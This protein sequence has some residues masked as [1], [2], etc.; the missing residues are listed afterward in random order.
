M[1]VKTKIQ[2][3][4]ST[5]NPT[6]GC[7]GC[8]I[9]GS[10]RRSCYAGT[11]HTRFGGV[12]Q[13]YAPTF[14]EVTKFPGRMA[15]AASYSDLTGQSRPDKPWLDGL[16]RTVFVSDMSDSLSLSVAFEYLHDEI[17]AN[18]ADGPGRRHRWLW[19]T[20]RPDRMAQFSSWLRHRGI[21]W[22]DNLWAGTSITTQATTSRIKNL[23]KVGTPRTTRFLSVEPQVESIDLRR[24][25]PKLDWVIQGGESGRQARPFDMAWAVDLTG[26]CRAEGVSYFL[27]QLGSVVVRDGRRMSFEDGHAGDWS[28]WPEEVRVREMPV[29]DGA[30]RGG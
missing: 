7:D 5:V 30:R 6:M 15:Q 24:W 9:W 18:V 25:L 16:P 22:P 8:E 3:C 11:L 26:L 21:E 29:P 19:L 28:E 10:L 12:T 14:E 13:G 23:L 20:K 17:V 27:K 4:D 1:A 2:W